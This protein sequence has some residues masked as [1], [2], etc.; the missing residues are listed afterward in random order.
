MNWTVLSLYPCANNAI[1]TDSKKRRSFVTSLFTA[2]YGERQATLLEASAGFQANGRV[3]Q[4]VTRII[5]FQVPDDA[6]LLAAFGQVTSR[7]EH[8]NHILR[9]TIKTLAVEGRL[10]SAAPTT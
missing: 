5:A 10:I 1:N 7:H 2:G 6:D 8:L 9:M 3:G 4:F